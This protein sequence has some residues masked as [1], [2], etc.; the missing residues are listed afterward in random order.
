MKTMAG[1][2]SLLTIS[3]ALVSTAAS[4]HRPLPGQTSHYGPIL[5][6]YRQA[7]AATSGTWTRLSGTSQYPGLSPDTALLMTDGTVMMH[8]SCTP[9][10]WRLTPDTSES[11]VHGTWNSMQFMPYPYAPLYFA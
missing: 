6:P 9:T 7:S 1:F 11:Y 10:W 5:A 4:A 8:D 2:N 3:L